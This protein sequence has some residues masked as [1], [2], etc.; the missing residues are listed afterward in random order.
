MQLLGLFILRILT[1][2]EE[3]KKRK[4]KQTKTHH[5]GVNVRFLLRN[6]RLNCLTC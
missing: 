6:Y 2:E 4:Q 1:K 3:K 5:A